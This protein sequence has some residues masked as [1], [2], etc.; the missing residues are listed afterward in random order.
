MDEVYQ[1]IQEISKE[2]RLW[3]TC[4][5]LSGLAFFLFPP[6][7]HIIG[8]LLLW[9]LKREDSLFID[10]HGKEAV[11]FQISISIY[12]L[13]CGLLMLVFVGF[14]LMPILLLFWF[15]AIVMAAVRANEGRNF[16]Y[17]LRIR[18]F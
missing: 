6:I 10:E 4:C 17:P 8:P 5:H 15:I 16:K 2:D 18:F 12:S 9:L 14:I 1:S 7:G 3:A 13:I 11:N